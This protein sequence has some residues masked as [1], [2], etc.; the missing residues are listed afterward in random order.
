[1][2]VFIHFGAKRAAAAQNAARV[3]RQ[4]GQVKPE[5]IIIGEDSGDEKMPRFDGKQT[6]EDEKKKALDLLGK[7]RGWLNDSVVNEYIGLMNAREEAKN[8]QR[9][10]IAFW[11]SYFSTRMYSY[12][13][14]HDFIS[15]HMKV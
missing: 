12:C 15:K 1:M 8:P 9:P 4:S 6:E 14:S 3:V 7:R 2:S 11:D 13:F 10:L 5:V